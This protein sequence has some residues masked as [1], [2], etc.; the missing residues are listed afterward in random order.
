MADLEHILVVHPD[1]FSETVYDAFRELPY[2]GSVTVVQGIG[3]GGR[4]V[5]AREVTAEEWKRTTILLTGSTLPPSPEAVP[6]LKLIQLY[7]AGSNTIVKDPFFN[8]ESDII[9]TTASGTHGPMISEYV[10]LMLMTFYHNSLQYPKWQEMKIWGDDKD[11]PRRSI[12][13]YGRTMGIFGYGAIGRQTARIAKAMGMKIVAY[14][15]SNPPRKERIEVAVPGSGDPDGSLPDVWIA[16]Q[17]N[18]DKFF[19]T[20]MDV[21][22][23][24]AP[25]TPETTK[26]INRTTL[27]KLKGA[28]IIN[29]GRG[30]LVDT[31]DL[32]EAAESGLIDGAALDVTD[33]EPLPNG[34]KLYSAKNI[35]VTPHISGHMEAYE[36][37]VV[38][39]CIHNIEQLRAGGSVA[40]RL[41]K[42]KGY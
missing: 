40:N 35:F 33:P 4:S 2:V 6:N 18:M 31:D 32:I 15:F 23:I 11:F 5:A 24:S 10:I 41:D 9:Y 42:T 14:S 20:K 27:Q 22:L 28:Y 37:R 8:A 1:S 30:A 36:G 13:Q 19:D 38:K 39:I 16:G 29:I 17:E 25:L 3:Y 26:V 7:S 12:D 34:H 21:L